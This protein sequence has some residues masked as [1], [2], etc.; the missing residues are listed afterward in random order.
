M[1]RNVAN[2]LRF[3]QPVKA[4]GRDACATMVGKD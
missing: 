2:Q 3:S 1:I 4:A